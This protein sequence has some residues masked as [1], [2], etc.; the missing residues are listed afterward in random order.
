VNYGLTVNVSHLIYSEIDPERDGEAVVAF[1]SRNSWPFHAQKALTIEQARAV[2]L[3]PRDQVRS[4]WIKEDHS[5]VGVV[6]VLDLEDANDGSVLFDL[7]IAEECRSRRIGRAAVGGLV[8]LLFAEYPSLHRIE[9][10]T[11]IDNH[12]M[13]RVLEHNRFVLEGRLRQT[14]RSEDG[15]RHDTALYG[16]LRGDV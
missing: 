12:P 15:T 9:A 5:T 6:R 11:R 10:A 16:R 3:G 13:R 8:E 14:W 7:R 2:K 4:F 1:L